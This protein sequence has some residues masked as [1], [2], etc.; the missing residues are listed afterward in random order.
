MNRFVCGV[1]CHR[2]LLG[3][4]LHGYLVLRLLSL[5]GLGLGLGGWNRLGYGD[6]QVIEGGGR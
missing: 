5:G 4:S 6:W 2:Q 3:F 1:G